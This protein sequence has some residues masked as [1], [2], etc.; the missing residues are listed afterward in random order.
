[1]NYENVMLYKTVMSLMRE[2]LKRELI[3]TSEYSRIS[4]VTA[5]K[6]GLSSCSI[7]LDNTSKSE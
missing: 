2:L 1:M 6:C 3:S 4:G 7:F 5:E